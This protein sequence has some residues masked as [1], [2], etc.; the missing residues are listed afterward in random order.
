LVIDFARD[1]RES[2]KAN[3][4]EKYIRI[5]YVYNSFDDGTPISKPHRRLYREY[6]KH[7]PVVHPFST[8]QSFFR[9]LREGNLLD[10]ST[11]AAAN[12]SKATVSNLSGKLRLI[13]RGLKL[14]VWILGFRRYAQMVKLFGFLGRFE[15]HSFLMED[16]R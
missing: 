10:Q 7:T 16:R 12:Y 2:V 3:G 14:I 15:N 11:A 4:Y 9:L 8:A 1:Y 13:G 6:V 5:P